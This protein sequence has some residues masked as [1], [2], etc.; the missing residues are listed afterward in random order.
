[1]AT[2]KIKQIRSRIGS[3]KD[4]K[5]TLDAL[6][7]RKINQIVEHEET[8]SVLGMV[9]KVK[10]LVAILEDAPI[11]YVNRKI[12][13]KANKTACPILNKSNSYDMKEYK[14]LNLTIYKSNYPVE[15][16]DKYRNELSELLLDTFGEPPY[17]TH[18]LVRNAITFSYNY[19]CDKFLELCHSEKSVRF[20]Q[21]ILSQ[22]EQA[23]EVAVLASDADYP[24]ELD[25]GYIALYRRV[26]KWILEQACDIK[27]H[28]KEISNMEFLKRAKSLLNEL[29]FLG[30]MIFTCANIYAEQDMIE[31]VAEIIFDEENQYV[32]NHKHHY[33]YIIQEINKV[34]K[35]QS[36]KHVVDENG[37]PDM[38]EAID[39]CFGIQYAIL[40][41][42]IQEIHRTNMPKGGQYCGFDWEAL[43]LNAQSMFNADY[44]QAKVLFEGLTLN[45]NNKLKFHDLVC[46]PHSM[47]RYLY[48][49]ILIWNIEGQDFAIIGINGFKES[50][51]Q[52]TSNCIPW[53]KAPS[54]WMQNKC[55]KEYVHSKED[56]HD[57]WLDDDV[58]SRLLKVG[59]PYYRNITALITKEGGLSLNIENVG[60]IDFIVISHEF[61]KIYVADCKH[62]QGRYDMMSQKNDFSNFRKKKGYDEQ[63]QRKVGFIEVH[64]EELNY[65]NK[66]IYGKEQPEIT[67]YNVEGIFI[68]NTPT[69][70]MFNSDYRIYIVDDIID[71]FSQRYVDPEYTILTENEMILNVKY[72]YFKKPS[73]LLIDTLNTDNEG[74]DEE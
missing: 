58:E 56:A 41:T 36:Y 13:K 48:R 46:K 70:Y 5:R 15:L 40:T 68:I 28:N 53:G 69:F 12:G 66:Q 65:H 11:K 62:L 14:V 37:M 16:E 4:Q 23:T 31:D 29:M 60:E 47:Y 72:P 73:Y 18:D 35:N 22:H 24:A 25:R 71:V 27:L 8:P 33:N 21:L 57:K 6:G 39:N 38:Y 59:L 63:I 19:F 20:Y 61:K 49:P 52:L 42:V 50:I 45:R 2:I 9:N 1:M 7:L 51:M 17:S 43:P 26:L 54:E 74:G 32:I 10:H 64:L 67:G 30:N 3:P 44:K 55:F 34:F